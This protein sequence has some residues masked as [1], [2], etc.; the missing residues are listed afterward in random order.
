MIG[1]A[2]GGRSC[3]NSHSWR[4]LPI[5][6][7]MKRR[8]KVE[9]RKEKVKQLYGSVSA[10]RLINHNQNSN[11]HPLVPRAPDGERVKGIFRH[12]YE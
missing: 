7:E 12:S 10:G 6:A 1:G 4:R 5:L 9:K 8:E 11:S 2:E 3:S